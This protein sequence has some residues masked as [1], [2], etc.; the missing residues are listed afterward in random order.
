MAAFL[1]AVHGPLSNQAPAMMETA[2][3]VGPSSQAPEAAKVA[4]VIVGMALLDKTRSLVSATK[5]KAFTLPVRRPGMEGGYGMVFPR[6]YVEANC[7]VDGVL[8]ALCTVCIVKDTPRPPPPLT[9]SAAAAAGAGAKLV[10]DSLADRLFVMSGKQKLTDV[11]FDVDGQKFSAHRLVLAAQSPALEEELLGSV[12][13]GK[14]PT[15][16]IPDM[17]ASTFEHM[18]HY[19]YRNQLPLLPSDTDDDDSKSSKI[20][21]LQHLLVAAARHGLD[22]LKQLCE[23]TLCAAVTA[24]TVTST[25]QL[26]EQRSH[27]KLKASC[28]QFLSDTQNFTMVATMDD[29]YKLIQMYPH[30]L[31]EIRTGLKKPR[32]SP[33]PSSSPT[34]S[35]NPPKRQ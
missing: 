1:L 17:R 22:T 21:E 10:G 20:I 5:G 23:D 6:S 33:T 29:Y 30:L 11:C 26:A 18:L 32:L 13:E 2:E 27:P 4:M 24:D 15:I 25:L 19:I 12:A 16:T 31:T 28:L 34:F 14:I 8:V 9:S 3:K 35:A 7:L